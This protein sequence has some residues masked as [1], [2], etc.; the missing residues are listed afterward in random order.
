MG[1]LIA[2]YD[3]KWPLLYE[4]EKEPI[5]RVLGERLVT[6]E[7]IGSTAVSG[8]GAK[9]IIDV[10]AAIPGSPMS[11]SLWSPLHRSVTC[12]FRTLRPPMTASTSNGSIWASKSLT[13]T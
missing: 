5:L 4:S 12:F 13:C 2:D 11:T 1:V 10:L 6:I 8:L 3:L 7:H 9:P